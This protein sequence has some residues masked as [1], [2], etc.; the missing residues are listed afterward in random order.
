[1]RAFSRRCPD[2]PAWARRLCTDIR[3]QETVEYMLVGAFVALGL[4]ASF[5]AIGATVA[6]VY[7]AWNAGIDTLWVPPA[8]TGAR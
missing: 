7:T 5:E 8:P 2:P 1:M 6:A 4:L 3:G